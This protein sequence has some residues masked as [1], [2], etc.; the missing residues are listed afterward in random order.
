MTNLDLKALQLVSVRWWNASAYYGIS[1]T[2]AFNKAGI[3][4]FAA[5]RSDSP[6]IE[7]ARKQ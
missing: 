5:G 2:E 6:P 7:Y 1:L 4:C 3:T